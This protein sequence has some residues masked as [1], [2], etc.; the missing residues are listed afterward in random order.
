VNEAGPHEL[1][2]MEQHGLIKGVARYAT[3]DLEIMVT[4][5]NPKGIQSLTDLG[6][7]EI[8]LSMPNPQWEGVANQIGASLR[9]AGGE[10]LY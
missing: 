5:G 9:K 6:R 10:K 7:A 2:E 8:W 4:T 1:S 3:N